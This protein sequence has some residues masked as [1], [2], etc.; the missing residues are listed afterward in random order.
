MIQNGLVAEEN[1][2]EAGDQVRG[3]HELG[4]RLHPFGKHGR[5]DRGPAQQQHGNVK[6]LGQD[7]GLLHGVGHGREDQA[8]G[9]EC[10]QAE[11]D[12]QEE[13]EQLARDRHAVAEVRDA[14]QQ[15]DH[16]EV[17]QP[18]ADHG[19]HQNRQRRD[20]RHFETA[21]DI[22]FALGH[23]AHARAKKP[24]AQNAHGKDH[25]DIEGDAHPHRPGE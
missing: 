17:K 13:R 2:L 11:G 7:H 5:G 15:H 19:G 14:D 24:V 6:K 21:E 18:S 25:S 23:G 10:A 16:G 20:G 3:R 1:A 8:D 9:A 22:G 4:R 12:H